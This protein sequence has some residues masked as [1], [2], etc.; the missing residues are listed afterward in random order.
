MDKCIVNS[1]LL[2]WPYMKYTKQAFGIL[3]V[4]AIVIILIVWHGAQKKDQ[5]SFVRIGAAVALTGDTSAWGEVE[6]NGIDLAASEINAAGGINGKQVQVIYEDTKSS[7]D[8]SLS[9]V[10][11]L[12]SVDDV[13]DIIGPT[14]LDSY[15]GAQGAVKN[16]NIVMITPSAS[17]TAVQQGQP[18]PNIF[19]TWYRTSAL[20]KGLADT[21]RADGKKNVALVF[22]NDAYYQEFI[23]SFKAEAKIEGVNIASVDLINPGQTDFKTVFAKLKSEQVDGIVF[24]MYDEA[25]T[26]N[27]LR[28]HFQIADT[29]PLY[30]N[31][32]VRGLMSND[33]YKKFLEGTTF[34]ENFSP[35]NV[36]IQKYTAAYGTA[37][38]LSASTAYDAMN[39]L[40]QTIQSKTS[41]Q[42][43]YIKSHTFDTVSF[44]AATFDSIGGIN[45]SN[46]QYQIRKIVSGEIK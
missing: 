12:I 16:K 26:D 4:I 14:W 25:M 28:N 30:S 20:A 7:S 40:A 6:K 45:T 11:K 22:Q 37:P 38:V 43:A 19:S 33:Q 42:V 24:G 44:G 34:V 3:I 32:A 41:D 1:S 39:I 8:G 31:D 5:K 18:I 29:I 10:Q 17:I 15:P 46:S 21:V 2:S 13:S 23:D 27:F 35:S 9:A 36:F